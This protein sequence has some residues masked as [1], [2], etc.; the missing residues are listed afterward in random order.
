MTPSGERLERALAAIDA[1]NAG[2]PNSVDVD[3]DPRPL[4]LAHGELATDWVSRLDPSAT[5]AQLLAARAH[6][7]RRW[8]FP[9]TDFP[10]GR[11]G[12]LRWRTAAKK[13]HAEEVAELLVDAGYDDVVVDGVQRIIRKEGLGT[14]PAV[15]THEDALCLAF[16]QTQLDPLAEDL[17]DERTIVVLAKTAKKMS[18]AGLAAADDLPLTDRGARLLRAAL[19]VEESAPRP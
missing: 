8:A 1:V 3:G 16:L 12:Y 14:D 5:D 13:A 7:L 4:A 6:H 9:R 19:A 17:G 2:D 18:P 11:A 15:Q 10:E